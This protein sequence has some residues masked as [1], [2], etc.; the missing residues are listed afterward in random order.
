M[1]VFYFEVKFDLEVQG[2]LTPET[3]GI[4]TK[5]F[6][7][8]GP[9]LVILAWMGDKLWR[10][11]AS[12]YRTNRR[13]HRQT[14]ATTIPEGQN[15][16]RVKTTYTCL[17]ILKPRK[18]PRCHPIY[19]QFVKLPVFVFCRPWQ[20]QSNEEGSPE[21]LVAAVGTRKLFHRMWPGE[22]PWTR[23]TKGWSKP[24]IFLWYFNL[25]KQQDIL[26][27]TGLVWRLL[28]NFPFIFGY[29]LYVARSEWVSN[30][31]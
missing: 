28:N 19:P 14:Q 17:V 7:S 20:D 23:F 4:L 27:G 6:C 16:P 15:W 21:P 26:F 24:H 1:A 13:T 11:Q 29:F 18:S 9:N 22:M 12:D 8:S 30:W 10:G 31:V 5:V 3:I 25:N 2:Q